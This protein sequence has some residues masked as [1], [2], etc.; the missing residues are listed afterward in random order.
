MVRLRRLSVQFSLRTAAC[1]VCVRFT[2]ATRQVYIHLSLTCQVYIHLNTT[3]QGYI[4]LIATSLRCLHKSLFLTGSPNISLLF[5]RCM[6]T[7][8]LSFVRFTFTPLLFVYISLTLTL[9]G[10]HTPLILFKHA[11]S[12]TGAQSRFKHSL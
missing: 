6:Y 4:N 8:L 12:F 3:W 5:V 10:V 11:C 9:S 1:R 2:A 7:T